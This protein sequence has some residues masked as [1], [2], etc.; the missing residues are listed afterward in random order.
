[1]EYR[2]IKKTTILTRYYPQYRYKGWRKVLGWRNLTKGYFD[3]SEASEAIEDDK[4]VRAP[5]IEIIK[6]T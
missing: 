1:M 3:I 6:Y 5:K 4:L 2:I